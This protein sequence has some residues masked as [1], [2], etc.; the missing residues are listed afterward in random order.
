LDFAVEHVPEILEG[1][2]FVPGVFAGFFLAFDD[3]QA[4]EE[5][6]LHLEDF[7]VA[8]EVFEADVVVLF[9]EFFEDLLLFFVLH[10]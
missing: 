4:F 9:E 7:L 1:G 10:F 2:L 3:L 5:L 8:F 6:V